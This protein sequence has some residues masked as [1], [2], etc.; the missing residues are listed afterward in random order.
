[1]LKEVKSVEQPSRNKS[2]CYL[3]YHFIPVKTPAGPDSDF[4][5]LSR[6]LVSDREL[7]FST[8]AWKKRGYSYRSFYAASPEKNCDLFRCVENGRLYI[9]AENE[10]FLYAKQ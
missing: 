6:H 7:G 3:G 4:Y 2:F 9:P 1:M 5:R 10:L 8:Y